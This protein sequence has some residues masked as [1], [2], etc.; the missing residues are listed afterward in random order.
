MSLRQRQ[1]QRAAHAKRSPAH[2]PDD[3]A[4]VFAK[5][6]QERKEKERRDAERRH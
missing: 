4:D 2:M 1:R 3:L 6:E 5:M